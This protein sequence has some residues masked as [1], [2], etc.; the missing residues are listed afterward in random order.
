[1]KKIVFCAL[2]AACALSSTSALAQRAGEWVLAPWQ[3]STQLFPGVV[4]SNSGGQV[5]V[6]FDDGDVATVPSDQISFFNWRAGTR[7]ECRWRNGETWY[8]GRITT[9][10][11][12][13]VTMDVAY[14]DG[15]RERTRT[16]LCRAPA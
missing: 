3:G 8:G 12:D 6:Q 7:V 14:D 1:M 13:G 15:D 5:T 4:Q 2:A 11:A 10:S 16:G 9:M